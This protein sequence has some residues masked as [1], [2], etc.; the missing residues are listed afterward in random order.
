MKVNVGKAPS[1]KGKIIGTLFT[2][3]G[4]VSVPYRCMA[5]EKGRMKIKCGNKI[6]YVRSE[7]V[8]W[9]TINTY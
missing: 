3:R 4:Y 2:E 5:M 9:V 6:G 7:L 1:T 8:K